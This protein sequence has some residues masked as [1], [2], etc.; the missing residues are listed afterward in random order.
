MALKTK[1]QAA[2][3]FLSTYGWAL[4]IIVIVGGVIFFV[5]RPGQ[6]GE[7]KIGFSGIDVARFGVDSGS[8]VLQVQLQ[9]K[10]S[11]KI[12]VTAIYVESVATGASVKTGTS[13]EL[14]SGERASSFTSASLPATLVSGED[15]SYRVYIE[16]YF[17]DVGTATKFNST[18]TLAGT[19]S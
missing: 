8:D 7:S 16:Y 17:S 5:V 18:G 1:G 15:F 12:N 10:R 6:V 3:E 13:L 2:M 9:N 4:L 14:G 11:D 19:A